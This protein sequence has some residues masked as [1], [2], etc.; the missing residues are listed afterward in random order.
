MKT[1]LAIMTFV[2][3]GLN[4]FGQDNPDQGN[5]RT[6]NYPYWIISKDVQKIQFS[7]ADYVDTPA[8]TGYAPASKGIQLITQRRQYETGS[9]VKMTGVPAS[10]ISKGVARMQVERS[11]RR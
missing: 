4:A 8:L 6:T 7:G 11:N 1:T 10:V 5:R 3:I 9:V 2:I